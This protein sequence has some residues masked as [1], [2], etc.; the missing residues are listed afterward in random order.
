VPAGRVPRWLYLPATLGSA[1]L[2]LPVVALI[3]RADWPAVPSAI[4]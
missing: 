3:V 2:V 1:F 4:T